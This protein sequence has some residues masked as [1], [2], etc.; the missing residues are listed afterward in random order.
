MEQEAIDFYLLIGGFLV[1][2]LIF[3]YLLKRFTS[4]KTF[5]IFSMLKTKKPLW[6]FD[7]LAVIGKPLDWITEIGL[8]LGFG[9]IAA[10][11]LYG[12]ALP[13][14]KRTALFLVST[15]L[16]T[17]LF[18][19][20]DILIGQSFS[21]GFL[22]KELFLPIAVFFGLTGFGGFVLITLVINAYSIIHN[23]FTGQFSCPG[24]APVLPGVEVPNVP[25]SVP[26][27]AW[28]PLLL[29]VVIHELMHGVVARKEKIPVKSTGVLLLGF[30]PIGGFVE[31]DEK[32]LLKADERKQLRVFAA[33]VITNLIAFGATMLVIAITAFLISAT[34]GP[35]AKEIQNHGIQGVQIAEVKE[36][37][38]FCRNHYPAP[39]FGVLEPGMKVLQIN[40]KP[41]N[42]SADISAE[43]A[44][45]RFKPITMQVDKNGLVSMVSM[46]P[47]EIGSFGF[48]MENVPVEGF[49]PP[50]EYLFYSYIVGLFFGMAHWFLL[51]NLLLGMMNYLPF[52]VLDGG[53][54]APILFAPYLKFLGK[55]K[56][57]IQKKILK[58]FLILVLGLLVINALPLFI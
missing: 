21:Q 45:N 9:A 39:A 48:V 26:L 51:F 27:Y 5:F 58:T 8:V 55:N 16:L 29:V 37:I 10:D 3:T 34:I 36:T 24:V 15:I 4:A 11:Y 42:T 41:V 25:I 33:G 1:I 13:K 52:P 40:G 7:K 53:R 30:L 20:F 23:F 50:Q 22:T 31:P 49:E 32:A 38:E 35:W 57:E 54:I 47:N 18:I 19:A 44:L 56:Q 14:A 2:S 17:A 12:R 46:T 6:V 43:I 28:I